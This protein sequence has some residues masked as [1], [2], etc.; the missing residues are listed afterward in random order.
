MINWGI[1]D[2]TITIP[3]GS[4]GNTNTPTNINPEQDNTEYTLPNVTYK[5]KPI[6]YQYYN[7]EKRISPS[8]SGLINNVDMLLFQNLKFQG[9]TGGRPSGRLYFLPYIHTNNIGVILFQDS[10]NLQIQ[11]QN[12]Q[13]QGTYQI[14]GLIIY[15]KTGEG[16]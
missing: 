7:N 10:D 5:G 9:I 14:S 11:S 15:T 8:V 2:I 4:G 12:S 16:N 13:F 6:Y 3:G 1:K